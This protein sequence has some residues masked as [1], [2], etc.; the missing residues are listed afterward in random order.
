MGS[1]LAAF[2]TTTAGMSWLLSCAIKAAL[3]LAA[4]WLGAA[5]L[6]RSTAAAAPVP[7]GGS[8]GATGLP[9]RSAISERAS[10]P[11]AAAL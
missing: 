2:V 9:S 7:Q 1:A 5:L 11:S 4:S 8:S 6:R 3:L 10:T